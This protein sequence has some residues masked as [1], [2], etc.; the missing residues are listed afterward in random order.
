MKAVLQLLVSNRPGVLDRIVGLIRRR[1]WNIDSLTVGDVGEG[2]SQ[3]TLRL[4]GRS[5]DLQT[6][7][8][9][10]EDI[11]AV[12]HWQPLTEAD[13]PLRELLVFALP[14]S[15]TAIP[16]GARLLLRD[17]D[18]CTY[19]Y[20]DAPEGVDRCV[21]ALRQRGVPCARSGPLPLPQTKGGDAHG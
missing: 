8:D 2:L 14:A 5:L 20:T 1:S 10:L 19:E 12:R 15:D 11:D 6:L 4:E 3:I 7:G 16:E 17:G 9:H 13:T 21:H 18:I